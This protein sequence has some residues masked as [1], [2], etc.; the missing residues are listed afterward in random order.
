MKKYINKLGSGSPR[1]RKNG[2]TAQ[3]NNYGK[4]IK[5]YKICN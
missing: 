1:T 2:R 3:K 5:K 4:K